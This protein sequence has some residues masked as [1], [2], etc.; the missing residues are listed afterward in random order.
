M[1]IDK[2]PK[3]DMILNDY[4]VE[5]LA[6]E[7]ATVKELYRLADTKTYGYRNDLARLIIQEIVVYLSIEQKLTDAD[8]RIQDLEAAGEHDRMGIDGLDNECDKVIAYRNELADI[9]SS[10]NHK[11]IGKTNL[12]YEEFGVTFSECLTWTSSNKWGRNQSAHA[13][14]T[15]QS[16]FHAFMLSTSMSGKFKEQAQAYRYKLQGLSNKLAT[17]AVPNP[18][19]QVDMFQQQVID[20]AIKAE[21]KLAKI[22]RQQMQQPLLK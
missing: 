2:S 22:E 21:D 8:N 18:V 20:R 7:I 16:D 3:V 10:M 14:L 11:L 12:F 4:P 6:D 9:Q 15:Q 19:K 5:D 13:K 17:A 1:T